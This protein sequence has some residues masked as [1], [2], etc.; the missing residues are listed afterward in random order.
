M[1]R[2]L[3]VENHDRD[4]VKAYDFGQRLIIDISECRM[5]R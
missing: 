1:T 2:I 4:M 3:D 5:S